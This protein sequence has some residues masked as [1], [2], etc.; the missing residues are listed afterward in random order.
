MRRLCQNAQCA[1][2]REGAAVFLSGT[3]LLWM[4]MKPLLDGS[5]RIFLVFGDGGARPKISPL[6]FDW[7][8]SISAI[9][10]SGA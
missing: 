4:P 9:H 6:G 8:E 3:P 7:G 5:N 10:G 1:G 2:P